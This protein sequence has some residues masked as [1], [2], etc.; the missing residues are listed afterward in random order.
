M[1]RIQLEG[2]PARPPATSGP[3]WA[4][5]DWDGIRDDLAA[6][7]WYSLLRNK[8]TEESWEII[9]ERHTF[10]KLYKLYVQPHLEFA[11]PA[12]SPWTKADSDVLEKVQ[13]RAVSMV[14]GLKSTE[15]LERLDELKSP[16][17]NSGER[18]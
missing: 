8:N 9:K 17:Y 10:V 14:S 2:K 5:A 16:L 7:D 6:T 13:K 3:D 1:I 4:K 12:W 15:Y 11:V 18:R